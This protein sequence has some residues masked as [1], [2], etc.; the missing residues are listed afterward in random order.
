MR[1]ASAK[2]KIESVPRSSGTPPVT[3]APPGP[4]HDAPIA[5][6]RSATFSESIVAGLVGLMDGLIVVLVGAGYYW[7]NIGWN[8]DNYQIYAAAIAVNVGMTIS[9]FHYA[10]L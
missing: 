7:Y 3:P 4:L 6:L 8:P 5:S 1:I 10:R 2:Q 9:A